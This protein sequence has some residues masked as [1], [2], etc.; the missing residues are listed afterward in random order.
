MTF[1]RPE[2]VSYTEMAIFIDEH[3][4]DEDKTEELENQLFEYIYHLCYM[5]AC[6]Q[7]FFKKYDDFDEFSLFM[8]TNV[9]LRY[10]NPELE[11]LKS[12]LNYIK[13]IAYGQKIRFQNITFKQIISQE[14]CPQYDDLLMKEELKSN[15]QM[16]YMNKELVDDISYEIKI[17]PKV[18]Q[19]VVS[20]TPYRND[21]I[22]SRRLYLSC[23]LT[24]INSI[25]LCK[26][27]IKK[28]NIKGESVRDDY[29]NKLYRNERHHCTLL[30]R[31]PNEYKDYVTLLYNKIVDTFCDN[32]YEVKS[33]LTL[34]DEVLNQL[35]TYAYQEA[36]GKGD[37]YEE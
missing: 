14:H 5:L 4:Y 34:S 10:L 18:I 1:T 8:A 28:L 24:F 2:D 25:T 23:L 32:L 13:K 36:S 19:E 27:S 26:E 31:L 22:M 16:N 11:R 7:R 12:V 30:W 20:Q 33:S 3:I 29:V 35:L 6:K 21:R 37:M 9:Y 17:L 15:I